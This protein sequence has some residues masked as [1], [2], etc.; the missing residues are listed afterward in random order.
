V[1]LAG[2]QL[3]L[4]DAETATGV[5]VEGDADGLQ[6]GALGLDELGPGAIDAADALAEDAFATTR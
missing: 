2:D 1:L 5:P 6:L 4:F 3:G